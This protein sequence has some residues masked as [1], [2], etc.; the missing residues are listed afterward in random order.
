MQGKVDTHAR[1]TSKPP[2]LKHTSTGR[3]GDLTG[4]SYTTL[5]CV[6]LG[7]HYAHKLLIPR[8]VNFQCYF[9]INKERTNINLAFPH[10]ISESNIQ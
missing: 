7:V 3:L 2:F 8:T 9:K 5:K 4:S 10:L 6:T 1:T